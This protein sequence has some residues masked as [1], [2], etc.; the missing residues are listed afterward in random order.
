VGHRRVVP[1]V[2]ALVAA[3][4]IVT[5]MTGCSLIGGSQEPSVASAPAAPPAASKPATATPAS[6][7]GSLTV[8]VAPDS[9]A[10]SADVDGIKAREIVDQGGRLV[11]VRSNA[12]WKKSRIK[13][14]ENVP[15]YLFA[16]AATK[17]DRNRAVVVYDES[18]AQSQSAQTWLER[19][20]FTAVYHLYRGLDGWDESLV[21][22]DPKPLPPRIPVLYYIYGSD[23]FIPASPGT[24]GDRKR[25]IDQSNAF[26]RQLRSDFDGEFDYLPYNVANTAGLEQLEDFAGKKVPLFHLVDE[27]GRDEQFE[28]LASMTEVRAHL[29][30][31]ITRYKASQ[32]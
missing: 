13:D 16:R 4:V 14:S 21:G 15:M 30:A 9:H 12:E 19:N 22:T 18:G 7:S 20:G 11:D 32:D 27:R 29:A 28:G 2:A 1:V 25:I 26:V 8:T 23:D 6:A 24:T 17:W 31:A 3:T 5:V 10:I